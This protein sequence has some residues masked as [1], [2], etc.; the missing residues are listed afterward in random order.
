MAMVCMLPISG[1]G[2]GP[3]TPLEDQCWDCPA[4]CRSPWGRHSVVG[5]DRIAGHP[6]LGGDIGRLRLA[7]ADDVAGVGEG[8]LTLDG[9]LQLADLRV[10]DKVNR[11]VQLDDGHVVVVAAA[12]VAAV[13]GVVES[14]SLKKKN[15]KS[16]FLE[17]KRIKNRG[18]FSYRKALHLHSLLGVVELALARSERDDAEVGRLAVAGVEEAVG[19]GENVLRVDDGAAAAAAVLQ[20]DRVVDVDVAHPAVGGEV[21]DR[22]AADD[23]PDSAKVDESK[24]CVD[25]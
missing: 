16:L 10:L 22:R 21:G 2:R 18:S 1:S 7:P 4:A 6:Q 14:L 24:R 13:Q 9:H 17:K 3:G 20:G 15:G 5:Q 12:A 25:N 11:R 23:G 19:G 8:L